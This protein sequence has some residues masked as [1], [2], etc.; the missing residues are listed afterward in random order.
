M[1]AL[2]KLDPVLVLGAGDMATG[3]ARRL[4]VAGFRVVCTEIEKP[5][6]VRCKSSFSEAVYENEYAVENVTAKLCAAGGVEGVLADGMVAVVVDPGREIMKSMKFS[7]LVDARMTKKS[8]D[9]SMDE[10]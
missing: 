8:P 4:H 2:K 3:V 9:V 1:E 10:A 6:T 7:A 5:L